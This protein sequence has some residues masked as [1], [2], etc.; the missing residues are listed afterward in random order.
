MPDLDSPA[1]RAGGIG[2]DIP[3]H[4][5]YP[6]TDGT[7][8]QSDRQHTAYKYPGILAASL[9]T[10]VNNIYRTMMGVGG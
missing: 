7:I 9:S 6:I 5:V 1:K 4:R 2:I 8:D 10:A 3:W